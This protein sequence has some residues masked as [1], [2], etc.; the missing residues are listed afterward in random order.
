[1]TGLLESASGF[2]ANGAIPDVVAFAQQTLDEV[3]L[4][5]IPTLE[6]ESA[7][8]QAWIRTEWARFQSAIDELVISNVAVHQRNAEETAASSVHKTCR[9]LEKIACDGKHNQ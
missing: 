8:D 2:L 4:T 9:D 7:A 5:I 1:M 6:N 3:A